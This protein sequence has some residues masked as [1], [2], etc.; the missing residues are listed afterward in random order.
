MTFSGYL[1]I[2]MWSCDFV[3]LFVDPVRSG[4][5]GLV[6]TCRAILDDTDETKKPV[7]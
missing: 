5:S 2:D 3:R 1:P 4:G 6:S 7:G